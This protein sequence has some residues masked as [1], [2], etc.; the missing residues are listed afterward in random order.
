MSWNLSLRIQDLVNDCAKNPLENNLDASSNRIINLEDPINAQDAVTKSFI[1]NSGYV[2]NPLENN[3]DGGGYLI[4]NVNNPINPQDVATKNFVD[5]LS[6]PN[7]FQVLATGD[8]AQNESI[9]NLTSLSTDEIVLNKFIR[10]RTYNWTGALALPRQPWTP[11]YGNSI[12]LDN[13]SIFGTDYYLELPNDPFY[14]GSV[15]FLKNNVSGI[16]RPAFHIIQGVAG[17]TIV[18]LGPIGSGNFQGV[19]LVLADNGQ[20]TIISNLQA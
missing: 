6:P 10:M 8:D 12:T 1:N 11:A 14:Y 4:T 2:K 19:T 3:L 20:Y 17:P 16:G 13:A 5:N 7:L 15:F 18:T 9:T